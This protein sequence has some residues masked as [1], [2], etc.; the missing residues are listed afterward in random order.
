MAANTQSNEPQKP[1][2]SAQRPTYAFG[3]TVEAPF[4]E[5][6]AR[7]TEALK[8][9]GFG[10]LTTIDVKET[11]KAKLNVDF[12]RYLIL[13]AC[14]PQLAHHALE[15]EHNVGVLLPCNVVVH[16]AHDAQGA[17]HTRVDVADPVA[18]L[19]VIQNPAMQELASEA[20]TRLERVVASLSAST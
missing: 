6:I 7:V 10:V 16:D 9:E 12:E 13:G 8:A 19:G 11:M 5:A 3:T 2:A 20:R 1:Q 15:L 4:D 14:N 17:T 18:M